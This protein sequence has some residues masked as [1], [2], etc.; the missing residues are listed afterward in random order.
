METAVVSMLLASVLWDRDGIMLVDYPERGT[1]IAAKYYV[2]LPDGL[3]A[4]GLQ[5]SRQAFETMLLLTRRPLR[6]RNWQ[7]VTLKF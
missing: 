2:A 4:T 3:E 7:I 5:T 6:T 1:A